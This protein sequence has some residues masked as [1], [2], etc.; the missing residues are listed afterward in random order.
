MTLSPGLR[1]DHAAYQDAF[2]RHPTATRSKWCAII[3][4]DNFRAATGGRSLSVMFEPADAL[5]VIPRVRPMALKALSNLG[6]FLAGNA[7]V[8]H[9][10]MHHV[11]AGR[12]LM[13]LGAVFGGR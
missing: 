6:M 12:R 8:H 5:D 7:F 9:L 3:R 10:K 13:A 11:V 2:L 1:H 4:F